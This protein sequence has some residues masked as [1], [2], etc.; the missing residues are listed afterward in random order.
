MNAELPGER[1]VS[2]S[3]DGDDAN[4]R[5]FKLTFNCFAKSTR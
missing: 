2:Q 4:E 1:R 5:Q 3:R